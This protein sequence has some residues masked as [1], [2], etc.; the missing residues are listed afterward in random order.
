[1]PT[2]HMALNLR[3]A[4]HL[5]TI[6]I[7]TTTTPHSTMMPAAITTL[8]DQERIVMEPPLLPAYLTIN[9]NTPPAMGM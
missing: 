7:I 6:H 2:H 5:P 3:V 1:M 8:L 9:C 4:A